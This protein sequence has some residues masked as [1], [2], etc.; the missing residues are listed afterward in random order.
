ME[1]W[2]NGE[3]ER[4]GGTGNGKAGERG[5]GGGGSEWKSGK[6]GKWKDAG[7]RGMEKRGNGEWEA[8]EVNGKVGKRG[9][10]KAGE[11]GMGGGGSEWKGDPRFKSGPKLDPNHPHFDLPRP[12]PQKCHAPNALQNCWHRLFISLERLAT[13]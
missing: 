6:T 1:K 12:N 10:G 11:P 3:M 7:E 2:E 4:R 5:M 8:G 9:N 13:I